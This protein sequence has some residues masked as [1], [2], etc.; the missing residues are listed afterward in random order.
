M[1][2]SKGI[3]S[4]TALVGFILSSCSPLGYGVASGHFYGTCASSAYFGEYTT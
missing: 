1:V 2:F 3:Y 4:S